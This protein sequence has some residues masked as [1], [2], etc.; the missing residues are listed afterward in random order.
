MDCGNKS[1][2]SATDF[3]AEKTGKQQCTGSKGPDAGYGNRDDSRDQ[4]DHADA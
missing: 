4:T 3:C 1:V 2:A